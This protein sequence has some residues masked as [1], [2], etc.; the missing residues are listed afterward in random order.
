MKPQAGTLGADRCEARAP[1]EPRQHGC[2]L[3][4][5]Q[6]G[7]EV[8]TAAGEAVIETRVAALK[9]RTEALLARSHACMC[10]T[11][12]VASYLHSR[13]PPACSA[14]SSLGVWG[15]AHTT[16]CLPGGQERTR[17]VLRRPS[18][19]HGHRQ[20]RQPTLPSWCGSL[21]LLAYLPNKNRSVSSVRFVSVLRAR[22]PSP[23][24]C[25]G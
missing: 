20:P 11:A 3:W 14:V 25:C 21:H 5:Q 17:G 16:S 24:A 7:V 18:N 10:A 4:V 22:M 13:A 1:G 15:H 23:N 12:A 19:P 9:Q 2:G 6:E 8:H